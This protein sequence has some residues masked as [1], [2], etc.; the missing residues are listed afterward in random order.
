VLQYVFE[1]LFRYSKYSSVTADMLLELGLPS[2]NTL[3]YN[4]NVS[5]ARLS[6]CDNVLV[7]HVL[8]FNL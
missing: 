8:Q 5:F 4:Y 2:F 1:I 6:A 7:Q 3:I